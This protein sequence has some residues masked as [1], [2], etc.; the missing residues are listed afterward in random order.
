V[1]LIF[2]GRIVKNKQVYANDSIN[3]YIL[4]NEGSDFE[5]GFKKILRKV[6]N[7]MAKTIE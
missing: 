5:G 7:Q 1:V 2:L 6:I 4:K 3:E